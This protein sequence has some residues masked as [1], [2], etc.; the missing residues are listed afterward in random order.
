MESAGRRTRRSSINHTCIIPIHVYFFEISVLLL[1]SAHAKNVLTQ[2]R[3]KLVRKY[4]NS[5]NG[6]DLTSVA[7]GDI[8]EL[9]PYHA[10]LLIR[11]GW[12]EPLEEPSNKAPEPQKP[13]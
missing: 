2:M 9:Q 6:I 4:A 7:V 5:L 10:V 3:I 1:A 13:F 8:V 12:A 11:E